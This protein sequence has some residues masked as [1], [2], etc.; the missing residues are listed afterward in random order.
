M[1]DKVV[2]NIPNLLACLYSYFYSCIYEIL[3][4]AFTFDPRLANN[5]WKVGVV[6]ENEAVGV[7]MDLGNPKN[8]GVTENL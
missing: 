5:R 1:Y 2:L 7:G 8:K 6:D 4:F 3:I